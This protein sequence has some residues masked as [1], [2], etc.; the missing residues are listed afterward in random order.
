[1]SKVPSLP[2]LR[3]VADLLAMA[4][5]IEV[6]AIERYEL[7]ADQMETHNNLELKKIFLDLANAEAIHAEEIRRLAGDIDL[8][9]RAE[10]LRPH[11]RQGESPEEAD[12]GA[13]HYLMTPWHALQ[14]CLAGEKRALAFFS[15]ILETAGD[16]QVKEIAAELVEEEAEHV[17][18]VYR[19]LAKY[20][21]PSDS[22]SA[23]TDA[24]LAQD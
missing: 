15:S 9:G 10:A 19:L 1:M 14:L 12:L 11:W 8:T 18:V 2:I 17:N 13:A 23:D 22:W 24:P 7:L 6:D 4:H 21:R 5:R 16:S 3:D 20:P